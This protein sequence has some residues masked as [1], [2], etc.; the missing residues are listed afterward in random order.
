VKKRAKPHDDDDN[1]ESRPRK[2]IK[3]V[4]APVIVYQTRSRTAAAATSTTK[5]EGT[6]NLQQSNDVQTEYPI[7][8]Y[9]DLFDSR[10]FAIPAVVPIKIEMAPYKLDGDAELLAHSHMGPVYRKSLLKTDKTDVDAVANLAIYSAKRSVRDFYGY[11]LFLGM[12]GTRSTSVL[13]SG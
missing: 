11:P 12:K 10:R 2:R 13:I 5:V 4:T 1:G 3:K 9:A 7:L 6:K 8:A